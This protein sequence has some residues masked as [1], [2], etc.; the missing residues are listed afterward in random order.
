M[1]KD[2]ILALADRAGLWYPMGSGAEAVHKRA[3]LFEFSAALVAAECENDRP[4]K[5]ALEALTSTRQRMET[6]S[7]N[8]EL[9]I[10]EAI[11]AEREACA[12]LCGAESQRLDWPACNVA[13]R[14]SVEI[15]E[16]SNV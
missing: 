2:E 10:A 13:E 1:Q 7:L 16:R 4:L 9:R 6:M 14:L 12:V 11:Q 8:H 5:M 15:R 3:R